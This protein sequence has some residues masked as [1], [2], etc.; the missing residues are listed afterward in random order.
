MPNET[1]KTVKLTLSR[2]LFK[3]AKL[4][5]KQEDK[6]LEDWLLDLIEQELDNQ[7]SVRADDW[8]RIDHR[9]DQRTVFLERRL[10]GL[11]EKIDRLC[12]QQCPLPIEPLQIDLEQTTEELEELVEA[13]SSVG[14]GQWLSA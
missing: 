9:I 8:G 11:A 13:G 1:D 5:A 4:R 6:T 12:R 10:D 2:E 7:S 14:V 3:A